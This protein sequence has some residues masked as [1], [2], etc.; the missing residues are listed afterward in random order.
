MRRKITAADKKILTGNTD[1]ILSSMVRTKVGI[2]FVAMGV[3]YGVCLLVAAIVF[4]GL[5]GLTDGP[6][7]CALLI[8]P[9][10]VTALIF[11]LRYVLGSRILVNRLFA[12]GKTSI[13]GATLIFDDGWKYIEDDLADKYGTPYSFTMPEYIQSSQEGLRLVVVR[14]GDMVFLMRAENGLEELI[15][16]GAPPERDQVIAAAHPNMLAG[17]VAD[18]GSDLRISRFFSNYPNN[19]KVR[20]SLALLG[21]GFFGFLGSVF[22]VFLAYG[23]V[24]RYTAL[25]DRY[26]AVGLPLILVLTV[27]SVV[28]CGRRYKLVLKAKY[29][30]ISSVEAVTLIS[31][32]PCGA[33]AA[34]Y[35]FTVGCRDAEGRQV[36][37][38]YPRCDG[39]DKA[40]LA[41]MKP[42][43]KIYMY[44][45]R[46][47]MVF[48]GTK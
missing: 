1:L 48:F 15:P 45:Y 37:K 6:A 23:A 8:V 24:F 47:G 43:R 7:V 27:L 32:T 33:D 42:G 12:V 25:G 31:C 18:S 2:S 5:L 44:K 38:T 4:C 46:E 22:V 21:A 17:D 9:I 13:N 41:R 26:F 40:D 3:T 39:F 20:K 10:V 11:W 29:K 30:D 35:S 36:A 19:N 34:F 14:N 16:F 28:V